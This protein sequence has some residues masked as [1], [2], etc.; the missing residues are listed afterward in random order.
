MK[1]ARLGRPVSESRKA[2]R[3]SWSRRRGNS[4]ISCDCCSMVASMRAKELMRVP[5]SSLRP[6]S[7]GRCGFSSL[8]IC[9]ARDSAV[10]MSQTTKAPP[11][12]RIAV[13]TRRAGMLIASARPASGPSHSRTGALNA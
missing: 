5:I 6:D 2:S 1:S 12:I 3:M 13:N 10:A 4:L 7:A 9:A 11:A 8:L